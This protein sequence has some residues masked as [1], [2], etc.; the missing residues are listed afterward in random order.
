M[1]KIKLTAIFIFSVG[2]FLLTSCGVRSYSAEEFFIPAVSG[3]NGSGKFSMSMNDDLYDRIIEECMP[4]DATD[5]EQLQY[6]VLLYDVSYD[7]EPKD[8][9]SNGDKVN[10]KVKCDEK[11][12]ENLNIRF[13]DTEFT[14]TVSGLEEPVEL[15]VWD[16]VVVTYEGISPNG[17]AKIEYQGDNDFIRN[18]VRYSVDKNY[19]LSNGDEI[20]AEASCSQIKLD[21]ELYYIAQTQKS[22]VVEGI[23]YYADNLSGYDLSE[24]DEQLLGLANESADNSTWNKA[25]NDGSRLYGFQLMRDGSVSQEWSVTGKYELKQVKKIFYHSDDKNKQTANSYTIFYEITFP[26]ENTKGYSDA[27][28]YGYELGDTYELT[29]YA[30]AHITNIIVSDNKLDLSET[31][32]SA[33]Y[34][35]KDIVHNYIGLSL[36][37]I[38]T[39]YEDD[40]SYTDYVKNEIK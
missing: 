18:N 1:K 15:N 34:F 4:K 21:E 12:L 10:I 27:S 11:A 33:K 25:Y 9:L 37:E 29:I 20:T 23:P 26:C 30:E 16:N 14:Y 36:N 35:G 13:T 28:K 7:A 40:S 38:I 8:N 2:M 17:T 22:Y 39:K 31:K 32:S 19:G 6:E 3:F 5:M 24:L